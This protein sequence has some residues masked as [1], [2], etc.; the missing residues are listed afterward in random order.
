MSKYTVGPNHCRCHPETCCCDDWAIFNPDRSKHSTH[1]SK[2]HADEYC[3]L[4]NEKERRGN[5]AK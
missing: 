1:Y 4:L 2:E 5:G 3:F